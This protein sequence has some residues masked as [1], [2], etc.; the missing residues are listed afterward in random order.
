M[1][2]SGSDGKATK[3]NCLKCLTEKTADYLAKIRRGDSFNTQVYPQP[4]AWSQDK[5]EELNQIKSKKH[6]TH[7]YYTTKPFKSSEKGTSAFS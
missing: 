2:I 7:F 4:S 3:E 5:S 1:C 6:K